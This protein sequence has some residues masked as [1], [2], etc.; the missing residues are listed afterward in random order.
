MGSMFKYVTSSHYFFIAKVFK[1]IG[2]VPS[3]LRIVDF[4]HGHTGSC[5]DARAFENTAA[6]KYPDWLFEGNEFAWADSAY[7]CT[8]QVIPVHKEPASLIPNNAI[9]DRYVSRL[10]VR[11]EHTMGALKGRFQC[12]RGLRISVDS[13]TEHVAACNWVTI[14]I[15]LH[16]LVIDVECYVIT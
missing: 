5:H 6:Y 14:A 1:Q 7:P 11:S 3:N 10:R 16:N 9:F 2:N 15:I 13:K 12:L 8:A 4:S